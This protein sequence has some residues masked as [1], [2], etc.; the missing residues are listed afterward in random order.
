MKGKKKQ[1][2]LVTIVQS[3]IYPILVEA[4]T[5]KLAEKLAV[6][7]FDGTTDIEPADSYYFVEHILKEN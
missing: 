5:E 7:M 2:W 4:D 1:R 3:E 6:E